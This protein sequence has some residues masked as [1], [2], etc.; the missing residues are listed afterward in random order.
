MEV[1][2]ASSWFECNGLR[3][4]EN[5][6][7]EIIFTLRRVA[8]VGD[9]KVLGVHLDTRLTWVSHVCQLATRLSRNIFVLRSLT[10]SVSQRVLK[11]A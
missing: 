10:I 9:V 4:N 5:K 6:T 1:L 7:Q 8:D 2:E 3:L 11:T